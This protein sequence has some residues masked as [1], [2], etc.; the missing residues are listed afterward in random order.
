MAGNTRILIVEDEGVIALELQDRLTGMGYEIVGQVP[1]GQE[2]IDRTRELQ[3]DVVLMDIILAGQ[4]DGIEASEIIKNSLDI[5]VIFLTAHADERTLQR[6]KA[7]QPFGY[8]LKPFNEREL[9][10]SIEM[11]LY[12][13]QKEKTAREREEWL[14]ATLTSIGDAVITVDVRS[15]VTFMNA[16]AQRLTGWSVQDVL[17]RKASDIWSIIQDD[18]LMDGRFVP[19]GSVREDLLINKEG[20]EIPVDYNAA[21]I[22][23][24]KGDVTGMVFVLRD[25]TE[26]KAAEERIKYLS[27]HDRLTDLYSRDYFEEELRRLDTARHLPLS[28][29]MGDVNGLKLVNDVFGHQEGDTLLR[30]IADALKGSCRKEDMVARWGGDEFVVLLP[31]TTE[32][33]AVEFAQRV[34]TLCTETN[35]TPIQPSIALGVATK[36]ES[37]QDL[38]DVLKTAEDRMYRNKLMDR[39]STRSAI[40]YSL[41]RTVQERSLEM[42]EHAVRLKNVALDVGRAVAL[43]DDKLDELSLLAMLHDIGKIAIPDEILGKPGRLLPDEWEAMQAHLEIGYRIV[44]STPEL[45]HI[46]EALLAHHEWWDGTGYPKKLRGEQ[47]PL[48]SRILA[49]ADAYDVMTHD[50]PYRKAVSKEDAI[51]E[52]EKCIGTQFDPQLGNLFVQ[53]MSSK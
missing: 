41:Q 53:T 52:I 35:G 33:L 42:G 48:I 24:Y 51:R 16:A 17:G 11:A 28:L 27:F 14:S 1:S 50:R 18:G 30:R 4:M 39:K 45:A 9:Q 46:G 47:I 49:I 22:K 15:R 3:P 10:V 37:T 38:R 12:K 43:P 25:I 2:A 40:I 36:E 32:S 13:H 21:P 8:I 26:R 23:N 31:K 6:A 5:P 44:E 29:I 20:I 34:R 19:S 7:T